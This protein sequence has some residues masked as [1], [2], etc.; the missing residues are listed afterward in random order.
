M[1][2]GDRIKQLRIAR[3]MTLEELGRRVG[4]GKSTVRKW[5]TGA[6]ANMRRDKIAKLAEALGTTVMDIMGIDSGVVVPSGFQSMPATDSAVPLVGDIAC[7]S[8]ILADTNIRSYIASPSNWRADFALE[9]H[10]DSMAPK[11]LDGDVVAIRKVGQIE[12]GQIAA[13]RID[14]DATLKRLYHYP[15]KLILQAENPAYEPIVLLESDMERVTIEG[16]AV[17]I[18]RNI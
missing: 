1:N 5:E 10:G 8:P 4:V 3:D 11:I 2:S 7:G 14:D 17:G 16:L 13:V 18:M 6:I 12:N 15:D 9:C